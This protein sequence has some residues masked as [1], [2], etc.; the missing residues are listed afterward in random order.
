M[1]KFSETLGVSLDDAF[2]DRFTKKFEVKQ[3]VNEL[4]IESKTETKN[5]IK[6]ESIF[7]PGAMAMLTILVICNETITSFCWFA[8]LLMPDGRY[9]SFYVDMT[10]Y[11]ISDILFSFGT[12]FSNTLGYELHTTLLLI[13]ASA[14]VRR[15]QS[16]SGRT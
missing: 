3:D 2:L 11:C 4:K 7:K 9:F 5:E 15:K 6:S 12:L 10:V 8:Y 16:G 14:R 1:V 13:D